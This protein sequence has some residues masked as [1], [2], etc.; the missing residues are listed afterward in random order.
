METKLY[1]DSLV[2][3]LIE[4][5]NGKSFLY[6]VKKTPNGKTCVTRETSIEVLGQRVTS[7]IDRLSLGNIKKVEIIDSKGLEFIHHNNKAEP[8]EV[9]LSLFPEE[10]N[11]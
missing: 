9:Q 6:E 11:E 3:I 5:Q 1:H 8:Q 2:S 7:V 4:L 10:P